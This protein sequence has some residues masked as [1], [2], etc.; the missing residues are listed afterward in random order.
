MC[1]ENVFLIMFLYLEIGSPPRVRGKLL[2]LD[3]K[4]ELARITPACAGKTEDALLAY[5]LGE[6]HPRVCG[7]NAVSER[8]LFCCQGSPPRVR[9]KPRGE[10]S[11][12]QE[13]RITPACAGKTL[14]EYH[15][16]PDTEDH[17]RVCGENSSDKSIMIF[18]AGSPPRVRGKRRK[19]PRFAARCRITPA[20]AGKT[21]HRATANSI[22][23]DHPRVCGENGFLVVAAHG[24]N[25]SPPRVR[26]K[27]LRATAVQLMRR[28]TP[29]CAGKTPLPELP[30][31]PRRDHPRV[32]GENTMPGRTTSPL[33]GSPPRV[34]GKR[35]CRQFLTA[36]RGITP[37]CAGKTP[38]ASTFTPFP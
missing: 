36:R 15:Q 17:P 32:C 1:G 9:G 8:L 25:G 24:S 34:R 18:D 27:L 37:A 29:A 11:H 3:G 23:K 12:D 7:E 22:C 4:T 35:S 10:R 2:D 5:D 19:R 28:I 33:L 31:G 21:S 38:G 26:G 13:R 6:D 20:C 14:D 16:H 30:A